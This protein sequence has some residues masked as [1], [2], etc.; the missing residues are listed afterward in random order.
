LPS[1]PPDGLRVMKL[2]CRR[3]A[4]ACNNAH[5]RTVP[6]GPLLG[7]RNA[8]RR[9][10]F[11]DVGHRST[12][13]A[14]RPGRAGFAAAGALTELRACVR[15]APALPRSPSPTMSCSCR[16]CGPTPL[17]PSPFAAET[18]PHIQ[19]QRPTSSK[20]KDRRQEGSWLPAAQLRLGLSTCRSSA[21][22]CLAEADRLALCGHD[23]RAS[24]LLV[25]L[26][27]ASV[28]EWSDR[29]PPAPC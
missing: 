5:V 27:G 12:E 15:N 16:S 7:R 21:A 24:R 14:Q 3:P 10:R 25:L 13:R 2:C 22:A 26:G 4:V 18:Q 6:P 17:T 1:P 11:G 23:L 20:S 9:C 29:F 19:S 8:T 28:S